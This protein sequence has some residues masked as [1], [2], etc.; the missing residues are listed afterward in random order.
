[1]SQT[2]KCSEMREMQADLT[3]LQLQADRLAL[4]DF[5]SLL[6]IAALYL[7]TS[8]SRSETES[9]ALGITLGNGQTPGAEMIGQRTPIAHRSSQS[10]AAAYRK[11]CINQR[12][13]WTEMLKC[14]TCRVTSAVA[15]S[16]ANCCSHDYHDGDQ[17][18]RLESHP[19]SFS[20]FTNDLG[21]RFYCVSCGA[22]AIHSVMVA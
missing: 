17:N 21:C 10:P 22:M 19:A 7:K 2:L 16:Q 4:A 1:V 11:D 14:P 13:E 9:N 6:G 15:L 3:V 8:L 18:V 12:D 20:V 5:S